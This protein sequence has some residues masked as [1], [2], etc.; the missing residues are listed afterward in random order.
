MRFNNRSGVMALEGLETP[1]PIADEPESFA[2]DGLLE[3]SD[4]E[5]ALRVEDAHIDEVGDVAQTLSSM[6]DQ[7]SI[8]NAGEGVSPAVASALN[9]AVEHLCNRARIHTPLV[10]CLENFGG[11]MGG[12]AASKLAAESITEVIKTAIAKIVEWLKKT[13]GFAI[14]ALGELGKGAETM[15]GRARKIKARGK[16]ISHLT[17]KSE[18]GK[19]DDTM[20]GRVFSEGGSTLDAA[21]IVKRYQSYTAMLGKTFPTFLQ[22]MSNQISAS[23]KNAT[24]GADKDAILTKTDSLLN[25]LKSRAFSQFKARSDSDAVEVIDYA[26]PF[27]GAKMVASFT[28]EEGKLN[29][30]SV[31]KE[32]SSDDATGDSGV[33]LATLTYAQILDL[34]NAVE[35]EMLFGLYKD[36]TKTKNEL[37][38]IERVVIKGCEAVTR[39]QQNPSD[40]KQKAV[41]YSVDFLKELV[42][43]V[44]SMTGV[45][46]KY[47]LVV[48][49]ALLSYCERSIKMYGKPA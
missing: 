10:F 39:N 35:K 27:G 33:Q 34:A 29:G 42:S 43:S 25:T 28:K 4:T 47:D 31:S 7:L 20:L 40:P 36:Y 38:R 30:L 46:H 45:I 21:E 5:H 41:T 44:I 32:Q 24:D 37:E 1:P 8:A 3:A 13:I 22:E 9:A 15:V 48:A 17:L 26:L 14:T 6:S 18:S 11:K 2:S 23:V 49:K 16:A 19:I 12:H